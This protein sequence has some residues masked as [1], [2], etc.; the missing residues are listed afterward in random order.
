MHKKPCLIKILIWNAREV[1]N[2]P[3]RLVLKRLWESH[4]PDFLIIA[5]PW[6]S[7]QDFPSSFRNSLD[8]KPFAMNDRN[9]LLPNFWCLCVKHMNPSIVAVSSQQVSF[10]V[11]WENQQIFV[12]AI[13][14]STSYLDRKALWS[15][16]NSLQQ[17]HV[18]PWCFIGD[19]NTILGGH[20]K[21][22]GSS[23]LQASCID[24]RDW[25]DSNN[26]THTTTRGAEFTWANNRR[27]SS[28]V[29]RDL[30]ELFVM[31]LS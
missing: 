12:S 1:A 9:A 10:S 8:L 4:K 7:M 14:A 25:S 29:K 2:L 22:G 20:E 5:K 3:T 24:F 21:R 31:T 6:M 16:L 17:N 11:L 23:P 27:G 13:Y 19:F 26:L 15:D 30:I 28:L 18:G